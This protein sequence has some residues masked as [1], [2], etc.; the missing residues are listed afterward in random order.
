MPW[1][2]GGKWRGGVSYQKK[3]YRSRG[4]TTKTAARQWEIEKLVALKQSEQRKQKRDF[5]LAEIIERF[6]SKKVHDDKREATIRR[7][8]FGLQHWQSY[9]TQN[10]LLYISEL[11][12]AH[13]SDYQQWR[14]GQITSRYKPPSLTTINHE[15]KAIR[16]CF[17]WAEWELNID[18]PFHQIRLN[19]IPKPDPPKYLTIEEIELIEEEAK[20]DRRKTC[21][22]EAFALLVRTGMR[23][24]EACQLEITD[25][26]L[27]K[28][29]IILPALKTKSNSPRI[30]PIGES[31]K[32]ILQQLIT[33]AIAKKHTLL[34]RTRTGKA[35]Q[36]QNLYR[37]FK[38]ILK[39]L[40]DEGKMKD[41]E[42][43]G[44]HVLRKTYISH[45]VMK[46]VDPARVMS[47]VGHEEY[48]TMK[49]YLY[50][51]PEYRNRSLDILEY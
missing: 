18:N 23:S 27:E 28:K 31:L 34:L 14:R 1:K 15:L 33:D 44:I 8:Q 46:G 35:Q 43:I 45:L 39:K 22:Y 48:S 50:L 32:P 11:E 37:R 13:L 10:N 25:V 16:Q 3:R 40:Y 47:I 30:I 29:Q 38:N 5:S 9:F 51:S 6:L 42:R 7:L 36:P 4:F 12:R 41:V 2:E 26:D 20:K 49:R 24:N 19:K 17:K 21:F